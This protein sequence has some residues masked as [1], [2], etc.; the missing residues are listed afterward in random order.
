VSTSVP[1]IVTVA[2]V[3]A[4]R[5]RSI[6]ATAYW[7]VH[8]P[9]PAC[10][11]IYSITISYNV[12]AAFLFCNVVTSQDSVATPHIY[13]AETITIHGTEHCQHNFTTTTSSA[14]KTS[15]ALFTFRGLGSDLIAYSHGPTLVGELPMLPELNAGALVGAAGVLHV[16]HFVVFVLLFQ[17]CMRGTH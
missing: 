8:A 9:G 5:P 10:E 3:L 14:E 1:A 7:H 4:V 12:C 13:S 2:A 11:Y 15:T 6:R 16:A 17:P